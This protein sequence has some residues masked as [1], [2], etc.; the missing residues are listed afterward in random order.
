MLACLCPA[1]C[2][3][4]SSKN[5]SLKPGPLPY[6]ALRKPIN[7]EVGR[8][9]YYLAECVNSTRRLLSVCMGAHD[10]PMLSIPVLAMSSPGESQTRWT[11]IPII[12]ELV[13]MKIIRW[14]LDKLDLAGD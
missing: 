13:S 14:R 8:Y 11:W 7:G 1:D 3:S 9:S 10:L 4:S 5:S 2:S 12:H 6:T